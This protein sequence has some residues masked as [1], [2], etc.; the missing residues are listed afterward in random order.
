MLSVG[1]R[2]PVFLVHMIMSLLLVLG[3]LI[4]LIVAIMGMFRPAIILS[5]ALGFVLAA[6]YGELAFSFPCREI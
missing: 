5:R 3:A 6:G 2:D 1:I 4:T